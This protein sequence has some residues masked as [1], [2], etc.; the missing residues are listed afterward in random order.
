MKAFSKSKKKKDSNLLFALMVVIG[1]TYFTLSP[2]NE[3]THE[4]TSLWS[5]LHNLVFS[6]TLHIV[7]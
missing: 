1:P 6:T 3:H 5:I 2:D 7:K 4:N